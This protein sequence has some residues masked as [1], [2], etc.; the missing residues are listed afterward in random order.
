[1]KRILVLAIWLS[2]ASVS[3][4]QTDE[5]T[6]KSSPHNIY[7]LASFGLGGFSFGAAYEFMSDNSA[8]LGGH[9]RVVNKENGPI[10]ASN[11]Y[12]II[13]AQMGH[14]FYKKSWDLAFTPSANIINIDSVSLNPDDTSAFGPGLSISLLC[15]LT[16]NFS[17]GFDNARYWVWFEED[18]QGLVIDEFAIKGRFSF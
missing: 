9:I 5:R 14:H 10:N 2:C 17:L 7:A 12:T 13:G 15:S 11:G 8:G 3:N 18:Y 1:M 6:A 16:E 4:A